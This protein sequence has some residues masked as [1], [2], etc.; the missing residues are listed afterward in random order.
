MTTKNM[1]LNAMGL[2]PITETKMLDIN[3]GGFN[4]VSFFIDYVLG[5][6]IDAFSDGFKDAQKRPGKDV[7]GRY[8]ANPY[9]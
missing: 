9:N 3:G 2:M 4:P 6:A 8:L 5:K 7:S 1:D